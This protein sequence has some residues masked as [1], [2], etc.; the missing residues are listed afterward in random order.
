MSGNR[1]K[2]ADNDHFYLV[3]IKLMIYSDAG[4]FMM[5]CLYIYLIVKP[6]HVFVY[7][8]EAPDQ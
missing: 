5:R 7:F 6:H 1:K 4:S 2:H 8:P 3:L